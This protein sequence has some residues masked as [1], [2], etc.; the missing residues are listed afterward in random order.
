MNFDLDMK[1]IMMTTGASERLYRLAFMIPPQAANHPMPWT[2]YTIKLPVPTTLNNAQLLLDII[3]ITPAMLRTEF[4]KLVE[5]KLHLL[6]KEWEKLPKHL[7]LIETYHYPVARIAL[8][9]VALL[10]HVSFPTVG[11]PQ[12]VLARPAFSLSQPADVQTREQQALLGQRLTQAGAKTGWSLYQ[13]LIRFDEEI[14]QRVLAEEKADVTTSTPPAMLFAADPQLCFMPV[15]LES[16]V[17]KGKTQI[18]H[19]NG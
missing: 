18:N 3:Q 10:I 4:Y 13:H 9:N 8:I 16:R 11:Q 5:P 19:K 6:L 14:V 17:I 2:L 12:E 7:S 1:R 15:Y